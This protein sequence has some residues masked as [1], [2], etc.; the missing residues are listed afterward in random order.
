MRPQWV[1]EAAAAVAAKVMAAVAVGSVV[2]VE[3]A[4]GEVEPPAARRAVGTAGRRVAEATKAP[5][6]PRA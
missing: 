3:A 1:E 4:V 6:V 2:T 5:M